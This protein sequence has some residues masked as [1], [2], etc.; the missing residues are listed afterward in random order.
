MV[1]FGEIQILSFCFFSLGV[2][3]FV[4]D[5]LHCL[6]KKYYAN[7]LY[8]AAFLFHMQ[9]VHLSL[10]LHKLESASHLILEHPFP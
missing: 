1:A 5:E 8:P 9:D 2:L 3:T 4:S 10:Y 7:S 6:N